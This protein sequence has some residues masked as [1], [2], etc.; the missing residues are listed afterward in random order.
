MWYRDFPTSCSP[1]L[2]PPKYLYPRLF[3]PDLS[4]FLNQLARHVPLFRLTL[5]PFSFL[6]QMDDQYTTQ[7][8]GPWED[9]PS[10]WF[11]KIYGVGV[12]FVVQQKQSD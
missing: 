7:S 5:G 2:N 11:F 9:F 12:P 3:I 6:H 8:S 10:L 1:P 4:V